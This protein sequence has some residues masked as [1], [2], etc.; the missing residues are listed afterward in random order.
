MT[1]AR[2]GLERGNSRGVQILA[3]RK[4][5]GIT[6][7]ETGTTYCWLCLHWWCTRSHA[8]LGWCRLHAVGAY[9]CETCAK[10]ERRDA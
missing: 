6:E 10:W 7:C 9:R 3:A 4:T 1:G 8:R 2:R 5:A